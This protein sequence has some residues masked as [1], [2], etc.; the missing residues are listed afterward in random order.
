MKA[1][2]YEIY[3]IINAVNSKIYIGQTRQ[4]YEKRFAQHLCPS[5]G[6]PALK[7]AIKKYGKENFV[8]NL[9]DLAYSQKEANEKEKMWIKC[10][11]SY[12]ANN[13]YNL[14]MGGCIGE[15][16]KETILKMSKSK[17]GENNSFYNRHHT[18]EAKEK[19]SAWKKEHYKLGSH[20]R[21]KI[22]ICTETGKKYSCASEAA[23]ET[24]INKSH[25]ISV[26]NKRYGRK[27]AGGYHWEWD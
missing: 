25:I 11:G 19:M 2:V 8:C 14:S 17:K 20:P 9:L 24:G 3:G 6:S 27:T 1:A 10:T 22:I 12:K 16:N 18:K 4:G 23:L 7:N 15:F 13:G 26:A 5:D 21:A